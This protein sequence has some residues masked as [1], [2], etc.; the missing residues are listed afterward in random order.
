MVQIYFN[1][2]QFPDTLEKCFTNDDVMKLNHDIKYIPE[3]FNEVVLLTEED[4]EDWQTIYDN[5]DSFIEYLIGEIMENLTPEEEEIWKENTCRDL[6]EKEFLITEE[7]PHKRITDESTVY[8]CRTLDEIRVVL[9]FSE[10]KDDKMCLLHIPKAVAPGET[11]DKWY[12]YAMEA[13]QGI[14]EQ[15][16]I[17]LEVD[18]VLGW[19]RENRVNESCKD[20]KAEI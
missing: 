7:L 11:F 19:Q 9:E 3:S 4:R 14:A 10:K 15:Y 17:K 18:D 1:K 13:A 5:W 16:S 6:L 20:S 2:E 12:V 8:I